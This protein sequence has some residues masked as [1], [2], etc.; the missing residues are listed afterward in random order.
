MLGETPQDAVRGGSPR[1][2]GKR[3]IPRSPHPLN[4]SLE[5]ESSSIGALMRLNND[6]EITK[7]PRLM[8]KHQSGDSY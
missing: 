2:R 7:I 6:K 3:V 5:T 8:P 4:K 1:S